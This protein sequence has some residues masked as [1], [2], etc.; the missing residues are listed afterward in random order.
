MAGFNITA[1]K[2]PAFKIENTGNAT[3]MIDS[4][5]NSTNAVLRIKKDNDADG[6]MD[7]LRVEENG[8]I[9]APTTTIADVRLSDKNL[10]TVEA[11]KDIIEKDDIAQDSIKFKDHG[12]AN[13]WSLYGDYGVSFDVA[14]NW[15]WYFSG[16]IDRI[17]K[18]TQSNGDSHILSFSPQAG[19]ITSTL[20]STSGTLA[21]IADLPTATSDLTN[22]SNFIP[23]APADGNDY[24]RNNNSWVQS[25]G[26]GATVKK[27]YLT[28]AEALYTVN[29]NGNYYGRIVG[30]ANYSNNMGTSNLST[31]T[32]N[33][34]TSVF[35]APMDVKL[36]RINIS[37]ID[38]EPS[39]TTIG[40]F[41]AERI[42]KN[43]FYQSTMI[44]VATLHEHDMDGGAS[45]NTQR[46]YFES[47]EDAS[48]SDTTIAQDE[49]VF[50]CFKGDSNVSNGV[51]VITLIFEEI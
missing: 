20:P 35:V 43:Y 18:A 30:G 22:D 31:F 37:I 36:K 27:E 41:K 24:V 12:L 16:Y 49:H 23:D 33:N 46:Q 21:N 44:N 7:L 39:T 8:E 40:L 19:G 4:D 10:A 15:T 2:L 29:S 6:I 38:A 48:I 42:N 47:I 3:I 1:S 5:N 32:S 14:D 26:G 34:L 51:A 17:I 25:S 11:V 28:R 45:L 13:N 50:L 9:S